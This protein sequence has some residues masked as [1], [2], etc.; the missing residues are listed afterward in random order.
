MSDDR[1]IK[2]RV[3][4]LCKSFGDRQVLHDIDINIPEGQTT[5]IIGPAASGKSVLMKCL[6]GLYR[7][8][9]GSIIVDD[10]DLT[11]ASNA[12][13]NG[14]ISDFGVLFQQGGLFDSLPIWENI[15]FKLVNRLKMARNTARE[16]ALKKLALV[17]LPAST[18]DLF[19]SEL[20]GGMQKRVG[21]ARAMASDPSCLF[22]DNPTAGLDPVTSNRI[23]DMVGKTVARLGTTMVCITSD[24]EAA[25]NLYD[26]LI[27]LNEGGVVWSGPSDKIDADDNPYLQQMINGRADG[28]IQMQL[29]SEES[30]AESRPD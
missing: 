28:P 27:M 6:I 8:D 7:A 9:R 23:N 13:K 16:V 18:A 3:N 19:P 20:S 14:L 24:M 30:R 5:V 25:H 4:G 21:L 2:M 15:A 26:H 22:L 12:Q 10:Q 29:R 11:R 1:K 17:D